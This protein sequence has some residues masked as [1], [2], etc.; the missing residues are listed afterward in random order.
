MTINKYLKWVEKII[1]TDGWREYKDKDGKPTGKGYQY[2]PKD[3]IPHLKHEVKDCEGCKR[4]LAENLA[5][6][7][8]IALNGGQY[9]KSATQY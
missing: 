1:K 2:Y 4:V 5:I 6:K 9:R 7:I 3:L 8:N